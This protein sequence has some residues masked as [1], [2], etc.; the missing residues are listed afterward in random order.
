MVVDLGQTNLNQTETNQAFLSMKPFFAQ[1]GQFRHSWDVLDTFL[2]LDSLWTIWNLVENAKNHNLALEL[3]MSQLRRPFGWAGTRYLLNNFSAEN[4]TLKATF[5]N[6]KRIQLGQA[7]SFLSHQNSS[8]IGCIQFS[9][10]F[11]LL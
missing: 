10:V 8:V 5:Y 2:F 11:S 1:L 7:W 4:L 6:E 3:R 9:P